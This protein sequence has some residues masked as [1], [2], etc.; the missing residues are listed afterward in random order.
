MAEE[1]VH[2]GDLYSYLVI[3][4]WGCVRVLRN[5]IFHG[6]STNRDS[7]NNDALGSALRVSSELISV[8]VDAMEA[9]ADKES[10]WPRI[11]VPRRGSPQHR[12][13]WGHRL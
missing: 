11:P 12:A 1:A 4:L 6:G 5:Q 3:L 9:R 8:F 10:E 2:T 7:L 13:A